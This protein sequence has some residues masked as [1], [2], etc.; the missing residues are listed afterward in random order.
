MEVL[1]RNRQVF[2]RLS[3]IVKIECI[4]QLLLITSPLGSRGA[5]APVPARKRGK[6]AQLVDRDGRLLF[7]VSHY[8]KRNL[9][10]PFLFFLFL[11]THLSVFLS[12]LHS[13]RLTV[14][15]FRCAEKA[16]PGEAPSVAANISLEL[17][18]RRKRESHLI[19]EPIRGERQVRAFFLPALSSASVFDENLCLP[20]PPPPPLLHSSNAFPALYTCSF[21][22]L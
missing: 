12:A 11:Y 1:K 22:L 3:F 2:F 15:F 13:R 9:G 7:S 20:S 21:L 10:A 17:W 16:F 18:E 6:M 8:S 19:D 5:V 14:S 4:A